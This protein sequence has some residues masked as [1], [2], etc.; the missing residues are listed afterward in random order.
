MHFERAQRVL[1]VR[2]DEDDRRHGVRADALEHVEAVHLRHLDVEEEDVRPLARDHRRRV[3][4]AALAGDGQLA[5]ALDEHAHDLP[6]ERL[7]VDDRPPSR[8]HAPGDRDRGDDAAVA[9][10][11]LEAVRVAVELPQ[12]LDRC[13][14]GRCRGGRRSSSEPVLNIS[15]SQVR[16][17]GG[18]RA[19]P[20]VPR[21]RRARC[22]G[23]S[24]SPPAAGG[25]A[26]APRRGAR[27]PRRRS[28]RPGGRRSARAGCRGSAGAW[29]SPARAGR[30]ARR[31]G[32]ACSAAGPT[33]RRSLRTAS[34][35]C[36]ARTSE[37]MALS[38]LNRKCGWICSS[39][40]CSRARRQ[41]ALERHGV[42]P[43][44][45]AAR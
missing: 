39:S 2:G 15:I 30:A 21:S 10:A 19:P 43:M 7:V 23:G 26:S 11:Q 6:R 28:A 17:R 20:R 45:I 35:F 44:A 36:R 34:S 33:G 22:R 32:R 25:S 1:V 9:L 14:S 12:P 42:W 40:A 8:D 27:R 31:R 29:P 37:L 41:G 18:T 24:R 4:A 5:V 13:S 3:D 16:R 38:V